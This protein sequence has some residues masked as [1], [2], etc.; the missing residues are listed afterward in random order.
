MMRNGFLVMLALSLVLIALGV[1]AVFAGGLY[2][3]VG[4]ALIAAGVLTVV[5]SARV[6]GRY[7]QVLE[8]RRINGELY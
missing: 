3:I 8:S 5:A 2:Q 6:R 1:T 4:A 7:V